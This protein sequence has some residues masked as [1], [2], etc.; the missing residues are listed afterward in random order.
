MSPGPTSS[1]SPAGTRKAYRSCAAA[2]AP[3][4]APGA[5]SAAGRGAT[6]G[7]SSESALLQG[8]A[9]SSRAVGGSRVLT[10]AAVLGPQRRPELRRPDADAGRDHPPAVADERRRRLQRTAV[11]VRDGDEVE[12]RG[13]A[14]VPELAAE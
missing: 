12:G 8:P 2:A 1:P 7:L 10:V 3:P 5:T 13:P 11:L 6:R 9:A 4:W 14:P